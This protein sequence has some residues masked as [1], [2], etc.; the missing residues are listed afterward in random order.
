MS[1]VLCAL[2]ALLNLT[3]FVTRAS[4]VQRIILINLY[5]LIFLHEYVRDLKHADALACLMQHTRH[6]PSCVALG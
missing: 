6:S 1:D 3:H 2:V 4:L 5:T